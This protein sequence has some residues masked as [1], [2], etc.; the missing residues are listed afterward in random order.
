MFGRFLGLYEEYSH[1]EFKCYLDIL[2][3]LRN[4]Y[5]F[6]F[7]NLIY[8]NHIGFKY[9]NNESDEKQYVCFLKA[10]EC[11]KAFFGNKLSESDW[12]DLKLCVHSILSIIS[13]RM[14]R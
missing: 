9:D 1:D 6:V 3:Y 2:D 14:R 8:R 12:N 10:T 11:A 5:F 13:W 7:A 4:L